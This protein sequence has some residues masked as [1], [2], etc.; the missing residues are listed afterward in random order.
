[1]E[2]LLINGKQ[3]NIEGLIFKIKND[4]SKNKIEIEEGEYENIITK[5]IFKKLVPTFCQD[6][7]ASMIYF[8]NE[9]DQ[10]YKE[11]N[12][13]VK[14]LYKESTHNNFEIFFKDLNSKKNIIYT[15]SKITE[16]LFEKENDIEN[17]YGIFNMQENLIENNIQSIK[18]EKELITT[19]K[20][21][22]DKDIQKIMIIR[23]SENDM[24]KFNSN[25]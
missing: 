23:F 4:F 7:M 1:M 12:E 18:E 17:K 2:K 24:N 19:L 21:F 22:V 5:E 8:K 13:L 6:I 25:N 14:D 9:L 10:N 3:H 20:S 11:F 16:N 15:F